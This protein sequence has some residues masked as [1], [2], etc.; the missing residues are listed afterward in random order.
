GRER[1]DITTVLISN[2]KYAIL[3]HELANVGANPG[4]T[5][6]SMMDL[7][8]PDLDWVRIAEGMGVAAARATTMIE[9]NELLRG[10]VSRPGPFLIELVV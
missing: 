7:S 6:L 8:N 3:L 2:R 9:F 4:P 10:S 1:L 5:A